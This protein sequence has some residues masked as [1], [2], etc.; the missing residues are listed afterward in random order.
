MHARA[1]ASVPCPLHGAMSVLFSDGRCRNLPPLGHGGAGDGGHTD[2]KRPRWMGCFPMFADVGPGDFQT[3]V[4]KERLVPASCSCGAL[5][6]KRH[7]RIS[8]PAGA[9]GLRDKDEPERLSGR[10]ARTGS[11]HR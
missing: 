10:N 8:Y 6:G 3:S 1:E 5:G 9:F 2:D 7:R 4:R 11:R